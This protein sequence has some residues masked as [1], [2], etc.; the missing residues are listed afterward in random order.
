MTVED[1]ALDD[2]ALHKLMVHTDEHDRL[3]ARLR[4]ANVRGATALRGIWGFRGEREP[5]GDAF[6]ALRRRVLVLVVVVD[7]PEHVARAREIAGDA[8]GP[9]T[10]ESVAAI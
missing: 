4:H 3:M 7:T 10:I 8:A 5:H 2:G 1:L 6:W 9:V